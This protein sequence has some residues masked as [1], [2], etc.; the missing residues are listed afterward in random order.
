MDDKRS[1][2]QTMVQPQPD[3]EFNAAKQLYAEQYGDAI[4]SNWHWKLGFLAMSL[5]ALGLVYMNFT[6]MRVLRDFKPIF[7]R[8]DAI[9]RAEVVKYDELTY[10]P[11]AQTIKYFL[12]DFCR[13]YYGR[14]RYVLEENFQKSL[15]FLDD[16]LTRSVKNAWE[17]NDVINNFL[18][19]SDHADIEIHVKQVAIE[20]LREPPYKASVDFDQVF[21]NPV[22]RSERDRDSYT[23]N[24]IFRFRDHIPT[25]MIL[26]NPIGLAITYFRE[27]A[28][29][30]APQASV[31]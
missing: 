23:A 22:D 21:Y 31:Q 10:R 7:V 8:V 25:D 1:P 28:A 4:V 27:D 17:K 24:F 16:K 14:N 19:E 9:G 12:S 26:V 6:T 2:D 18:Q 11:E 20:Q 3:P 15:L 30:T 5:V 29:F 13:T